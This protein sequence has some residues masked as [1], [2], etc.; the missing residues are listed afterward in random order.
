MHIPQTIRNVDTGQKTEAQYLG[1][2]LAEKF[3]DFKSLAWYISCF[4]K[5]MR[6]AKR[7]ASVASA[8]LSDGVAR[9]PGALFTHYFKKG[10]KSK[11]Q[12]CVL[13]R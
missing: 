12:N 1:H 13:S 3:Q 10:L 9:N 6:L 7:A 11:A 4:N 2:Q 8:D 5:N